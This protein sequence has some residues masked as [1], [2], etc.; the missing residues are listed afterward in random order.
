MNL[1]TEFKFHVNLKF[2]F[3]RLYL[4]FSCIERRFSTY[5]FT[6]QTFSQPKDPITLDDTIAFRK[7]LPQKSQHDCSLVPD[8]LQFQTSGHYSLVH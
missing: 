4:L 1:L 2:L 3:P 5:T 8:Y 6:T 7:N